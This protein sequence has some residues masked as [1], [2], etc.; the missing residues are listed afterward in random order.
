M[1][2]PSLKAE[3]IHKRIE[4]VK[5]FLSKMEGR[6]DEMLQNSPEPVIERRLKRMFDFFENLTEIEPHILFQQAKIYHQVGCFYHKK[7]FF[8]KAIKKLETIDKEFFENQSSFL[9]L[10]AQLLMSLSRHMNNETSLVDAIK[11][12]ERCQELTKTAD[13]EIRAEVLWDLG[14]AWVYLGEKSLEPHDTK[15]GLEFFSTASQLSF[16]NSHFWVDYAQG[17][18]LFG[19]QTA[20]S[21]F[22][23]E[24]A[25]H[26]KKTITHGG[27]EP[28]SRAWKL[29]VEV[30]L[31]LIEM[32]VLSMDTL[33][34]LFFEAIAAHPED[35]FLW[36]TWGEFYLRQ[37]WLKKDI[38]LIEKGLEKLTTP[39]VSS[40]DVILFSALLGSGLCMLGLFIDDLRVIKEGE[41]RIQEA[42]KF[43]PKNKDLL[44][45]SGLSSLIIGLYY[46]SLS[47]FKQALTLFK[48]VKV[49]YDIY[50]LHALFE[51]HLSIA[52]ITRETMHFRKALDVNESLL[53]WRPNSF[54]F[55]YEA[56]LLLSQ[57]AGADVILLK[58]A[59]LKFKQALSKK[60]WNLKC[61]YHYGTVLDNLGILTLDPSYFE[62]GIDL[63]SR[64]QA[65]NTTSNGRDILYR[66]AFLY[67]HL[68]EVTRDAKNLAS[69]LELFETF[70][71]SKEEDDNL[72]CG[73]GYALLFYSYLMREKDHAKSQH[74]FKQAEVKLIKA[75]E[76][77]SLKAFYHLACLYSLSGQFALSIDYLKKAKQQNALPQMEEILKEE[78][79]KPLRETDFFT[80]FMAV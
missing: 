37:G 63:L 73:W 22:L 18:Y 70:S 78:W 23:E 17:L 42:L 28:L 21:A 41:K 3:P 71:K 66:L 74:S 46:S 38:T 44:F 45:A 49:S 12:M 31:T 64:A 20:N 14:R 1:E 77:G 33:D 76:L 26:L 13:P 52:F 39:K 68:G 8:L 40:T 61:L 69:G 27:S 62:G 43:V 59:Q 72:Y 25:T 29:L 56:G 35:V 5:N 9:H 53:K 32:D 2:D 11:K 7:S 65:T 80:E 55:L 79:L 30:N 6:L 34:S 58:Q 57:F 4:Y 50:Y 51:T 10:Y 16:L 60:G 15:R 67:V 36:L 48:K 24:A 19:L 54:V 75:L 47:H